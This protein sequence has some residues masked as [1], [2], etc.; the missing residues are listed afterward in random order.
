MSIVRVRNFKFMFAE[1][2]FFLVWFG[3]LD[4]TG[5]GS[6]GFILKLN[7][8]QLYNIIRSLLCHII[9]EFLQFLR[10]WIRDEAMGEQSS[11]H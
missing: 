6:V 4:G 10:R 3:L 8:G 2:M 5:F 11:D 7:S 1:T 9:S